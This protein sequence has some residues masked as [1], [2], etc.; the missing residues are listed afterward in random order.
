MNSVV[1]YDGT[2]GLCDGLVRFLIK[3]D[4]AK[5]LRFAPLQS[6][7]AADLLKQ[8]GVDPAIDSVVLID[9]D[10]AYIKST[11]A[12]RIAMQLGDLGWVAGLAA[13]IPLHLRDAAYE[14]VSHHRHQWFKSKN[15]CDLPTKDDQDRFL[16][17]GG[18]ENLG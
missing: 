14:F 12:I 15:A 9:G 1:L 13:L 18:T 16:V 11:A 4:P 17:D 5:K 10:K 6:G 2:C 7:V 8:H 3:H